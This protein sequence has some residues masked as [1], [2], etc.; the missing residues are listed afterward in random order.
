MTVALWGTTKGSEGNKRSIFLGG[1]IGGQE[2]G[3][4]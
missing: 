1:A 4:S 3:K 2:Y